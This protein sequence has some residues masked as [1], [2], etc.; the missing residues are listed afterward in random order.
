MRHRRLTRS[1]TLGLALVALAAPTA[2]QAQ[3]LRTPDTR[4]A[5]SNAGTDAPAAPTVPA[6]LRSPD[7]RDASSNA[8]TISP[9]VPADLRSPDARD[10]SGN[11]IAAG[12]ADLR[13]PDSRDAAEG[14]GTFNAP[15]V[16]LIEVPQPSPTAADGMDWADAGIGAGTLLAV[17]LLGFGSVLTVMHR[18]HD[19]QAHRGSPIG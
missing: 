6:D 5:S 15:Q 19:A 7:T 8:N 18:R 9:T 1:A 4:D 10:T 16:A 12:P 3:D 17:V 13:T 11:A 14:R 2:A